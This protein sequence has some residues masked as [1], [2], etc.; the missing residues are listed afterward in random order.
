[1][2]K[3]QIE[4]S[5]AVLRVLTT[6]LGSRVMRPEFGSRLY[7]LLDRNVDS[8]FILDAISW[9]YEAIEKNLKEVK[10]ENVEVKPLSDGIFKIVV[11]FNEGMSVEVEFK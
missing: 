1:M 8:S 9:T 2:K 7:E 10:I 11:W 4:L 5:K 6:P 3:R